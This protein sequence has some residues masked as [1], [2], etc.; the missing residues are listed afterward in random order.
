MHKRNYGIDLL[1]IVSMYYVILIHILGHG[2]VVYNTQYLTLNDT[3]A[4]LLRILV[5][6]AVNLFA[7]C[8]GYLY[9][10]KK[11]KYKNIINLWILVCFYS[12]TITLLFKHV[13][14]IS[15]IKAFLPVTNNLYW[16]FSS[17]FCFMLFTPFINRVLNNL[18]KGEYKCLL[19]TIL[20]VMS[21]IGF[22][23]IIFDKD[24][25]MIKYG[26]SPLWIM[27]LYIFGGYFKL[28]RTKFKTYSKKIYFLIYM[29]SSLIM[30]LSRIIIL[31]VPLLSAYIVNDLFIRYNS[32]FILVNSISLFLLFLKIK[33]HNRYKNCISFLSKLSFSVYLIHEHP[34]VQTTFMKWR[35]VFLSTYPIYKM[36][37]I[38]LLSG[39]NI[40]IMCTIID[41]FRY[42]L[43]KFLK[44]DKFSEF[45]DNKIVSMLTKK[46]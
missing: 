28:Y 12:V 31:K 46:G 24:P 27:C 45:V 16:Y 43:F 33:V 9:V 41:I 21:G 20:F 30:L 3:I 32:I 34:L 8:T 40:Y 37:F 10:D 18:S 35:F 1:K 15:L 22:T 42:Y 19:G 2:G 23:S 5:Y 13:N 4:W 26:F 7:L 38:I 17:Y 36:I 39:L 14:I 29:L 25:V 6:C 44:V 11:F